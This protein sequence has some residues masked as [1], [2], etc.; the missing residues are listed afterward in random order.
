MTWRK[1]IAQSINIPA[2]KVLYLAGVGDT[3]RLA[4][5]MGIS[6][7]GDP[8]QYGLTLVLGGGEVTLL[9]LTQSYGTFA[10]NGTHYTPTPILKL[11]DESGNVLEDNSEP[12]GGQVMPASVASQ[13]ND[14]LSDSVA[15]APLGGNN[16][17]SFPGYDVA[18]KTGTTDNYRDAWTIGYTPNIAVGVWAGNNDNKPMTHQVSGFIVGPM[19]NE[20]MNYALQKT[21]SAP[22][23]RNATYAAGLK[24]VLRGVW[25]GGDSI[26]VDGSTGLPATP[27]T[28]PQNLQERVTCNVHDILYWVDRTNPLG[29]SPQEHSSDSQ[30]KYW[31]IPVL[32]WAAQN[33]CQPGSPVLV[34]PA[35]P[36]I[37]PQY[38]EQPASDQ[39]IDPNTEVDSDSDTN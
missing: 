10:Q 14:M 24:P 37:L 1:A 5:L 39:P 22:F 33:G 29:P 9:D 25:Q 32:I 8:K 23:T 12:A 21:V 16:L 18:V 6:T 27:E 20:F 38:Q 30:F 34:G 3:L 31:E 15:R 4:R 36:A 26:V 2:M 35:A 7:L 17:F 28:P 11:E 13:I 19:W